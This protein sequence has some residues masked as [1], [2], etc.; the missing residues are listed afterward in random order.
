M[1]NVAEL[2]LDEYHSSYLDAHNDGDVVWCEF[3]DCQRT[4]YSKVFRVIR[5]G[6]FSTEAS[7]LSPYGRSSFPS[8]FAFYKVGGRLVRPVVDLN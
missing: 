8:D 7:F 4:D 6:D 1:G 2:L 5:G 3:P